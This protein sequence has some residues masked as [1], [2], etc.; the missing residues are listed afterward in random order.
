[1]GKVRRTYVA[2]GVAGGWK[3]WNNKRKTFWG[4]LYEKTTR[5]ID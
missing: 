5:F 4:E 1:M 3:I 2:K